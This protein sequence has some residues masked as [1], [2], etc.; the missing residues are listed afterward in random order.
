LDARDERPEVLAEQ[1]AWTLPGGAS[2]VFDRA[3]LF[4]TRDQ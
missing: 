4:A 3:A 1:L 2:G